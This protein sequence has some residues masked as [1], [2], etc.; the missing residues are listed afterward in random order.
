MSGVWRVDSPQFEKV[1]Q[2]QGAGPTGSKQAILQ[3]KRL[4]Q[5]RLK[6]RVGSGQR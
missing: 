5:N 6:T 4:G 1:Q 2:V 3:E